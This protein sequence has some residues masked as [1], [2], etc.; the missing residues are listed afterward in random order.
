MANKTL[1]IDTGMVRETAGALR[2]IEHGFSTTTTAAESLHD[3]LG[4]HGLSERVVEFANSW[5]MKRKEMLE[6]LKGLS[7]F[8]DTTADAF[9]KAEQGL[10]DGIETEGADA[11]PVPSL[12]PGS[13]L[14]S[15]TRDGGGTVPV[16]GPAP[17]APGPA[18][19]TPDLSLPTMSTPPAVDQAPTATPLSGAPAP[20]DPAPVAPASGGQPEPVVPHGGP[21]DTVPPSA[22]VAPPGTTVPIDGGGVPGQVTLP[23]V[24]PLTPPVEAGPP[25]VPVAPPGPMLPQVEVEPP[26]AAWAPPGP[27]V[28]PVVPVDGAAGVHVP[29]VEQ[30]PPV[31][32]TMVVPSVPSPAPAVPVLDGV[33]W[34][35][36]PPPAAQVPPGATAPDLS[37][38]QTGLAT[39]FGSPELAVPPMVEGSASV[40][41]LAGPMTVA[42]AATVVPQGD[43][44]SVDAADDARGEGR[45]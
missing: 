5:S 30:S 19:P 35:G 25:V 26:A 17:A 2:T 38:V 45:I 13:A 37:G 6:N 42:A 10:K 36:S 20:A 11:A 14:P 3:A 21:V 32:P 33:D 28:P 7:G 22:P 31:L 1:K 12:N 18:L 23:V 15:G 44:G 9:D 24:P 40:A 39:W 41:G 34:F 4:H 16:P 29:P 27:V 8:L 43:S